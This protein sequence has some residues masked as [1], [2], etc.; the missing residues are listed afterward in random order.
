[1]FDFEQFISTKGTILLS[2]TKDPD[3]KSA[4]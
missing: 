2:G 3:Q 4:D 1:M